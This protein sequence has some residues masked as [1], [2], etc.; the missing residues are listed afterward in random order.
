L[1]LSQ[2][3][4]PALRTKLIIAFLAV[5]MIPLGVLGFLNVWTTRIA[6][7]HN[8]HEKLF[9]AATQTAT[10]IE[11]FIRANLDAMRTEAQL[12]ALAAYLSLAAGQRRGS[13]TEAEVTA[14]LHAL[15]RKDPLNISSYA[16]L[17]LHGRDIIDTF[18]ADIGVEKSNHSYVQMPLKTGL[19][20]VSPVHFS[21]TAPG[22][23]SLYFSSPVRN[24]Q[25]KTVGILAARY[26][27]AV[28]QQLLIRTNGLAGEQ[29]FAILFDENA[30]RLAHGRAPELLFTSVARLDPDRIAALQTTGRWPS[31]IATDLST[32]LPA[33][34]QRLGT[35]TRDKPY[36]TTRLIETGNVL[37]SAAVATLETQPWVVVFAQPQAVF[38]ATTKAQVWHTFILAMLIAAAVSGAATLLAYRLAVPVLRLT[39]AAERVATGDLTV[40]ARV[41][42]RDEIGALA[43]A[44]NSM[45]RQLRDMM[46]GLQQQIAE[47]TQA[48]H[49][50]Q[51]YATR[52]HMLANLSQLI[53]S[54]LHSDHVLDEIAKAA[55][56]LMEAPFVC[57]WVADEAAQTLEVRAFSDDVIGAAFPLRAL[58]FDEGAVGWVAR[59]QCRVNIPD[60]TNDA[61]FVSTDWWL[62]HQLCSFVGVPIINEERLL[63]VLALG[64][65]RPFAFQPVEQSLLDSFIAQ[66]AIALQNAQLFQEIQ[67]QTRN[68]AQMNTDLHGEIIERSRTEEELRR[69]TV[70]LEAANA[71]LDA[72]AYSISHDLRA[73]LRS[74]SGFSQI[75]MKDYGDQL[76]GDALDYLTRICRASQRMGQMIDDLLTLSRATRVALKWEPVDLS[77]MAAMIAAELSET[78]PDRQVW[79]EIA[80]KITAQGDSRVLR[81]V[82]EN[83]L[84]NAWKFT[85]KHDTATIVFGTQQLNGDT[86]YLVRDDGAGF[87]MAYVDKLF[88]VFQ[89]LHAMTEFEGTGIGLATVARLIRRHGGYI[90]AEGAVDQG[91]TFYFTLGT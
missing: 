56:Q 61:R 32:T 5:A 62:R 83:L 55:A 33:F 14:I 86:V 3:F 35:T 8:A 1:S 38:L 89:R 63:A 16:L 50:A 24:A 49:I 53:S 58:P 91:A 23:A 88:G 65:S 69:R 17:D 47:R 10:S 59:H 64:G 67:D 31:H 72:F 6:L 80:P 2:W 25:G 43:A 45:T 29:S 78:G 41:T 30:V 81:I 60:I 19:P 20:Y 46:V 7:V 21:R 36:F 73:P 42:S 22:R 44:F 66:A 27:A 76:A 39:R 77:A 37:L 51:A 54:S 15:S 74:L 18:T 48:E 71:E 9:G 85:S 70:Q 28:L 40:Q 57:F 13:A 68:L 82:L 75:L 84:H 11:A 26:N 87:D 79:W 52:L 12:P 34:V 90:W 4:Q